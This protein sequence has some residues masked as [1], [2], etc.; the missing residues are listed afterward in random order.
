MDIE[1]DVFFEEPIANEGGT[2]ENTE[3][4]L[5][6]PPKDFK[7]NGRLKRLRGRVL[8]RLLKAELTYYLPILLTVVGLLLFSGLFFGISLRQELKNTDYYDTDHTTMFFV[9]TSAMFFL[10][11]CVGGFVF[12][13]IYPVVRYNKSF[14]QNE[15]YLTFSLPASMEEQVFA[16]RIAAVACSL[17]VGLAV[18]LSIGVVMLF[19]GSFLGELGKD[20]FNSLLFELEYAYGANLRAQGWLFI[21]E[22]V[23]SLLIGVVMLPCLYAVLSCLLS[24]TAGKRKAG[25]TILLVFIGVGIVQ[26]FLSYL[27]GFGEAFLPDTPVGL[28]ISAWISIALELALTVGSILLEIWYLKNK[29][30]LK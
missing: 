10:F 15:G 8:G 24:K 6:F 4:V 22:A 9:V 18:A 17:I 12:M 7:K 27:L 19:N 5:P 1:K 30:D 25:L 28:H 29:L 2:Y 26:A 20:I 13:Q 14:F 11:A 16:K 3:V 23:L 21:V